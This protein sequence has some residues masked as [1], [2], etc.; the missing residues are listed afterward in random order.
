M[1]PCCQKMSAL[2][3]PIHAHKFTVST[4]SPWDKVN[5]DTM[6]PFPVDE[7]GN[8]YVIVIVDCF[9][10]FVMLYASKD[11]TALSAAKALLHCVGLFGAPM[12]ILSDNGP[13]YVNCLLYTSDAADE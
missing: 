7:N 5:I 10:R 4:F 11:A 9:S 12:Q 3:I 8:Q 1:C 6:G 2:Q 13:Q